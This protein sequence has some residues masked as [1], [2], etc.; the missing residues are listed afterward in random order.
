MPEL[1][2]LQQSDLWQQAK[3]QRLLPR[4]IAAATEQQIMTIAAREY[5]IEI[6]VE[7][8]QIAADQLRVDYGL[9]TAEKTLTWLE[10]HQLSVEDFE[11]MAQTR[12]LAARLKA[13]VVEAEIAPYFYR[14]QL[15]YEQ[16]ILYQL[17]LPKP[18]LA[19]EL[20]YASQEGEVDFL[21]LL[22]QYITDRSVRRNGGYRRVVRRQDLTAD[23]AAQVFAAA[24]PVILKPI[25]VGDHV[26]LIFVVE[27]LK[28]ELDDTTQAEIRE[29][30][31]DRWLRQRA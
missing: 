11:D 3:Y 22:H 31:F 18:E 30:L 8:L 14:H 4:L 23:L 17:N 28:P 2:S 12:C 1:I 16:A 24:A 19:M 27:I 26:Q 5:N 25:V 10:Q 15:D 20:F 13:Q 6:S 7:E 9:L 29:R 21:V